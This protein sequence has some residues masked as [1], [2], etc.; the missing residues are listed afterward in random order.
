MEK[1]ELKSLLLQAAENGDFVNMDK[2]AQQAIDQFPHEGMGYFYKGEC[3]VAAAN[4]EEA[5][6]M[7]EKAVANDA[8]N[9]TYKLRLIFAAIQNEDGDRAEELCDEL[10]EKEPDNPEVHLHAAL[11]FIETRFNEDA[12]TH[13]NK[14]LELDANFEAALR[15]R[16]DLHVAL[17]NIEGAIEDISRVLVINPNNEHA[18]HSRIQFKGLLENPDWEAISL[19]YLQLIN[20]NPAEPIYYNM[21]GEAYMN[22]GNYTKGEEFFGKAIELAAL[23]NVGEAKYFKNRGIAR[24]HNA[25]YA[26]AMD[27]F[28]SVTDVDSK[29]VEGYLLMAE[30]RLRAGD[31]NGAIGYLELGMDMVVDDRWRLQKKLGNIFL[32]QGNYDRAEGVFKQMLKSEDTQSKAEGCFCM[33]NMYHKQN[34]LKAA[35]RAWDKATQYMYHPQAEELIN[36]LCKELVEADIQAAENELI[37]KYRPE[38]ERNRKSTILNGLFGKLWK[39]DEPLTTQRNKLLSQVPDDI[40][41]LLMEAFANMVVLVTDTGFLLFNPGR[42]STRSV[43]RVVAETGNAVKISAQPV[44]QG[45]PREMT[46][47]IAGGRL[48]LAGLGEDDAKVDLFFQETTPEKIAAAHRSELK[49]FLQDPVSQFFGNIAQTIAGKL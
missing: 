7:Y 41:G 46:F 15:V 4:Y 29:D 14:A 38:F 30:A 48:V 3:Y 18:L 25:S 24:M 33:G 16:A 44:S 5:Q 6:V 32:E 35:Y 11:F 39:V 12:L 42:D 22:G 17:Q 26:D 2:L 47:G 27:D 1:E 9:T 34:N 19:D 36:T 13:L 28:R 37:E 31:N 8:S 40:R 10:L 45:K 43:Y 21:A 20:L 49:K 23:Y